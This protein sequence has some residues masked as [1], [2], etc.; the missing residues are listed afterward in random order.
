MVAKN[1]VTGD[2]LRSKT[3]TE[4]YA[5]GWDAIFGKK[6]KMVIIDEIIDEKSSKKDENSCLH[7]EAS[8]V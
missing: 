4:V 8:G 5:K 6:A 1:D 3:Q 7:S 2:S